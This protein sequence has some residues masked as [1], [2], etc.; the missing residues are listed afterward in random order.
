M[1]SAATRIPTRVYPGLSSWDILSRPWRDWSRWERVPRTS[2]PGYSQP[3]LRDWTVHFRDLTIPGSPLNPGLAVLGYS[4]PSLRD[5][6][7]H[8]GELTLA[9]ETAYGESVS[10]IEFCTLYVVVER[11]ILACILRFMHAKK[12]FSDT[13]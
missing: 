3:S 5:W 11:W 9:D 10:E 7:A 1:V 13:L 12:H 6:T 4:Q 8:F 2:V